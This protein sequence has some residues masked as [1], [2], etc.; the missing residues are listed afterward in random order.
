MHIHGDSQLV[1]HQVN[2]V[3]QT[4]DEKLIPY[5]R[6]V[7]DLK[8]YFISITF[9]QIPRMENKVADAVAT[10]STLLQQL[11]HELCYEFLVEALSYPAY[12]SP[13]TR[14][15]CTVVG[16]DSSRYKNLFSY[17]HDQIIPDSFN[18]FEK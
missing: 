18:S 16:Y 13:E 7:D 1:I 17:L 3:Y 10:L 9:E 8:K 5:K 12:D 11:E 15:I 2:D 4:K 14:M 6:M